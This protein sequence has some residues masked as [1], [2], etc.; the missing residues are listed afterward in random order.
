MAL[1]PAPVPDL[2]DI[3]IT[4]MSGRFPG[5]QDIDQFRAGVLAGAESITFLDDADLRAAGVPEADLR[6][7]FYVRAAAILDEADLFDAELFGVSAREAQLLDPQFRVLMEVSH[8]A[9]VDACLDPAGFPGTIGIYAGAKDNAYLE[10]NVLANLA[11]ARAAG[12]LL[13]GLSN[14]TDYLTTNIAFR[15]GLTG[16]A[17]NVVTACSTS[18]VAVHTAIAALRLGDCD[19]AIAGGVELAFPQICGY[20]YSEGGMYSADGHIRTF[21][22]QA[23]GTVFGNGCAV[24]VLKRLADALA[25]RDR[26]Y[27]VIRGSAINNDGHRKDS[28]SAPSRAGQVAAVTTCLARAAADPATVGYVEAHGTG[29]AVGDPIEIA[30]L[31]EAFRRGSDR[32]EY[33]AVSSV[34]PNVGHLGAAAGVSG[35]I[36]AV[37][38]VRDGELAPSLNFSQPNPRIAFARSPFY[39]STARQRWQP[40]AGPRRAIIN[41]FGIG[42]TNA[43]VLIEQGPSPARPEPA[44]RPYQLLAVSAHTQPALE[45]A[46]ASLG[47]HLLTTAGDGSL[48]DAAYTLATGRKALPLRRY[49][50]TGSGQAAAALVAD[51]PA[52]QAR[53][54]R[55]CA[56]LFPGQG[57]QYPG[58]ARELYQ[59]EPAF[60]TAFDRCAGVLARSHDMDLP[61][62]LLHADAAELEQTI[63]AQPVLFAVEYALAMLL[64]SMGVRPSAMAGHSVGEY[65]A[66]TLAGVLDADDA[67]RLVA[68]RGAL[69]QALSEPGAM[70]AVTLPEDMLRSLLPDTLDIAAVNAPGLCVVSG[71]AAEIKQFTADLAGRGV[72]SRELHTSGAFH[73]RLMDPVLERFAEKVRTVPLSAPTL[74]YVSNLSGT[75]ITADEATDPGYWV[76]HIRGCVRFAEALRL[77]CGQDS[78]LVEAGP[79]RVLT[80]LAAGLGTRTAAMTTLGAGDRTAPERALVLEAVGRAWAEGAEVDWTEFYRHDRRAVVSLPPY[81]YQHGRH[82]VDAGESGQDAPAADP[83]YAV[84]VWSQTPLPAPETAVG[85]VWV[86]FFPPDSSLGSRLARKARAAGAA[87]VVAGPGTDQRELFAKIAEREPAGLV[88]VH[89]LLTA[90]RPRQLDAEQCAERWLDEGFHAM[91]ATL[92][93]TGAQLPGTPVHLFA[94]TTGMQDVAGGERVEPAKAAVLGIVKVA[95]KEFEMVTSRSIDLAENAQD[96]VAVGQLFTEI[97]AASE[98]D[99]VAYRGAK[100]WVWSFADAQI[101]PGPADRLPALLRQRGT[102]LI[103]GGL[104]GIG[105][106]L[107]GQLARIAQARIVLVGRTGLPPREQWPASTTQQPADAT[108]RRIAAI[109]EMEAAGA[110]VL[111]LAADVADETQ[112]HRVAAQVRD[113]FGSVDGVF[114]LA[115]VPGAGMLETRTRQACQRVLRPKVAGTYLLDRLFTPGV[116]VL[117]SSVATVTGDFGLGDYVAANCVLNA[118]AA[119]HAATGRHV[120]SICWPPHYQTGMATELERPDFLSIVGYGGD[121][122]AGDAGTSDVAGAGDAGDDEAGR[123]PLLRNTGRVD[124]P[125]GVTVFDIDLGQ[126]GWVAA[127]HVLDG[128]PT[129]PSTGLVELVRAAFQ[130]M[131]GTPGAELSGVLLSRPLTAAAGRR[132]TLRFQPADG[133]AFAVTLS[134]PAGAECLR[135]T[136]SAPAAGPAPV[137]DLDALRAGCRD[138]VNAELL[139]GVGPLTFGRR[140]GGIT[141]QLPGPAM[142]L[143]TVQLPAEF[144]ADLD[145]YYVHPAMLDCCV[146][147]GQLIKSDS[148]YLPVGYEKITIRGPLPPCVHSII[149]HHDDTLGDMTEADIVVT[150]DSGRELVHVQRFAL[151]RMAEDYQLPA[152]SAPGTR[153]VSMAELEG[154]VTNAAAEESFLAILGSGQAPQIIWAPQGVRARILALSMVT[155][156]RLVEGLTAAGGLARARDV[157][158]PFA[159]P[160]SELERVIAVIWT[161]VLGVTQPGV[162]DQFAELGG[163]S[164]F[165]VQLASRIS[166]RLG[167]KLTVAQLFETP[168]IRGLAAALEPVILA[169]PTPA[170]AS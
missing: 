63:H 126:A 150:D 166:Q 74:P 160:T 141:A 42:G 33:C 29:T 1:D 18:L 67:I 3:A 139:H 85:G 125:R 7:P 144:T 62:L 54:G 97:C 110:E 169:A 44:A 98:D 159:A 129:M 145:D 76:R 148:W 81:P 130:E 122:A 26:V 38:T 83:V 168:T 23:T 114:H 16:P 94:V 17:M 116:F 91:L 61:R 149:R 20:R 69:M 53:A 105:L 19:A 43:C 60:R 65:V 57:A 154:A 70:A 32:G 86:L 164:L 157:Q 87:V 71:S 55:P 11:I 165:A 75:W 59:D 140:W 28:F 37:L 31:T 93:L 101:K 156:A 96:E 138:D 103:T 79:G 155:R 163:N 99:Q 90:S 107:G 132:A 127:E 128:Q 77:L 124:T 10:A 104:G 136:V 152:E 41:S 78:V 22:A 89:A 119:A 50:V 102:Y 46:T 68:E 58:M 134:G 13:S 143:V 66:A 21:D 30:A 151:L 153:T 8:A 95:P 137:Y 92:Q 108:A 4:G 121:I 25:D 51:L 162:D 120:L 109:R 47:E 49:A 117:Y 6:D 48:A 170:P 73:S 133:G 100:R 115:A 34:K 14:H 142:E 161:E 39:V 135:A 27:A 111:V 158:T 84:P 56:F 113:T 5:A 118:Y 123:H 131:T 72:V 36:N 35:L 2:C 24:V 9:L 106:L 112:M 52:F 146:S 12:P 88:V 15:L 82:W 64:A 147:I 45:A 167:I 80:T 40:S